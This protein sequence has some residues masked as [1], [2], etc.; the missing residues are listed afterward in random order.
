VR[1]AADQDYVLQVVE[2]CCADPDPE[3]H[4]LLT[5]KVFPRQAKIVASSEV[6][7]A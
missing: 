1:Y 4:R 5:Q 7:F 6:T 3:V 2:D